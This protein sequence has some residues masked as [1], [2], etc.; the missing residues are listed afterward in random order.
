M[1]IKMQLSKFHYK[2]NIAKLVRIRMTFGKIIQSD[3]NRKVIFVTSKTAF[4]TTAF[5]K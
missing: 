1:V 5:V 4:Y 2:A 3:C